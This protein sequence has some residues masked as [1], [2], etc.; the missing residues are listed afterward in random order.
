MK[1]L[2]EE[3]EAKPVATIDASAPE[4]RDAQFTDD[5]G[6]TCLGPHAP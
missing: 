1:R 2:N 6:I 3:G 4:P 5:E